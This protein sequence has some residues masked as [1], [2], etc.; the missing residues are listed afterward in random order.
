MRDTRA[1]SGP[2]TQHPAPDG[3][4]GPQVETPN[5]EIH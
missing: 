1:Q 2:W 4:F 5:W 3:I